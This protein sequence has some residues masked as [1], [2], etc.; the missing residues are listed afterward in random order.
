MNVENSVFSL[1]VVFFFLKSADV[2]IIKMATALQEG[3]NKMFPEEPYILPLPSDAPAGM[4]RCFFKNS[5]GEELSFGVERMDF[6]ADITQSELW[7]SNMEV[8]AYK[9]I[10]ICGKLGIEVARMGF[11]VQTRPDKLCIEEINQHILLN[12][13]KDSVE[14][15]I[16]WV[17]K[18]QVNKI[19]LNTYIKIRI[20]ERNKDQPY[21]VEINVNTQKEFE[22]SHDES[23]LTNVVTTILDKVE[24]RLKN[25]F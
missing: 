14:K 6:K 22:L 23:D 15:T 19:K 21:L 25:V 20:N 16:S 8:M 9:F 24:E 2:S 5:N 17:H 10:Q 7:K 1:Q 12:E 13:Y 4:P 11:A 18:N 3:F